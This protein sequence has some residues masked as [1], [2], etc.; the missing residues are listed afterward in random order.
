MRLKNRCRSIWTVLAGEPVKYYVFK[1]TTDDR[2]VPKDKHLYALRHIMLRQGAV[3]V[4]D[5]VR[6]L[7]K[8]VAKPKWV[9]STKALVTLHYLMIHS[10]MPSD[11][12]GLHYENFHY[13]N[14]MVFDEPDGRMSRS[15]AEIRRYAR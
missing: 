14:P 15:M 8:R 11:V 12:I 10:D 4:D 3:T 6:L 1:A 9:V 13:T 7:M 5:I 2:V